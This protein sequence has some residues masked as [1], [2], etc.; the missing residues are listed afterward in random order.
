MSDEYEYEVMRAELL[1]LPTPERKPLPPVTNNDNEDDVTNDEDLEVQD[2]QLGRVS[3]GIDEIRNILTG[4]QKKINRFKTVCGSFTNLLKLKVGAAKTDGAS[5]ECSSQASEDAEVDGVVSEE[6]T[7][8]SSTRNLELEGKLTSKDLD[9]E[10]K[11]TRGIDKL[12]SIL[13]KSEQAEISMSKQNKEMR[14][15][16]K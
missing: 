10:G 1:G 12:D 15:F 6:H 8:I 14:S 4:T 2:E 13:M 9:L 11:L 5:S 16:L 7:K 3:G